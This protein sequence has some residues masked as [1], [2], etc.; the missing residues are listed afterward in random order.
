MNPR[1]ELLAALPDAV[2]FDP[3]VIEGLRHDRATW[4][5]A[6]PPLALARPT[7]TAEVQALARWAT[8]HR[9]ALVPR[10]AGT[11]IAGGANASDGCVMVSFER[12]NRIL[13]VDPGAMIA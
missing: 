3:E 2:T 13:E 8:R 12:M 5:A 7:S 11:G 1:E 10:G 9:I 4:A 6:G